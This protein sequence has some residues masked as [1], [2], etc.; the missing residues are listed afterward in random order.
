MAKDIS[1]RLETPNDFQGLIAF[2]NTLRVLTTA[3]AG[4]AGFQLGL[5]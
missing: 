3:G 1:H 5:G 2:F 4:Y